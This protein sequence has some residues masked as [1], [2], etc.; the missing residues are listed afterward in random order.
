MFLFSYLS[1][2]FFHCLHTVHRPVEF[3]QLPIQHFSL[4][5]HQLEASS[6]P[7]QLLC[8]ASVSEKRNRVAGE[9]RKTRGNSRW[10]RKKAR[11]AARKKSPS[12]Q[13]SPHLPT[14]TRLDVLRF[15]SHLSDDRA[16]PDDNTTKSATRGG[17]HE[18]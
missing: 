12:V 6:D 4:S 1:N 16:R 13:K 14:L 9:N 2:L 18:I 5:I 15:K 8:Q 7:L 17:T 3:T 11:Q 10:Q